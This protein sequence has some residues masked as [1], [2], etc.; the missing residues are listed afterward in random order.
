MAS[1]AER[2]DIPGIKSGRVQPLLLA[3]DLMIEG[4][5]IEE[6]LLRL[7]TVTKNYLAPQKSSSWDD[8]ND[9]LARAQREGHDGLV[10]KRCRSLY[11]VSQEISVVSPDW[12]RL[13]VPVRCA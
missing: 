3:F 6:R 10:L 12:M 9:H 1:G 4:V 11:H 2:K 13:L 8:V 7:S 5:P